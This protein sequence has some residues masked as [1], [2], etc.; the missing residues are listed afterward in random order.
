MGTPNDTDRVI[1]ALAAVQHGVLTRQ[2]LLAE[3]LTTKEIAARVR[4]K[5]L[6]VMYP[7]VYAAGHRQLRREGE[8]LA[9]V[10][11]SGRGAALSHWDAAALWDLRPP[12]DGRIHVSRASTSGRDPDPARVHIHRV[13]TLRAWEGTLIDGIPT[14]TVARTLLDLAPKLRPAAIEEVI[15][16]A[17]RLNVFDLVAVRRCLAEHPRQHGAPKLRRL[18]D[19][20]SGVGA[21]DLR[22]TLEVRFLQLCADHGLPR[23]AVNARVAGFM[24]DF[25]WRDAR[26][27]VETDGYAYHSSREAFERDRERDQRLTLAGC[28]V[29]RFTYNQVTRAPEA[30]AARLRHLLR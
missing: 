30:V 27:V 3:E 10:F 14:T 20:L 13:G 29:L 4:A 11:A 1:A 6:V 23:P 24:V 21:A 18:L 28:T 2:Q 12:R 17:D 7:G 16:R 9:A 25:L 26:L 19:A 5:R 22:S 15:G 8:W